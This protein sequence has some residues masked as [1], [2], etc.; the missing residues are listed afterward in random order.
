[1]LNHITHH[2]ARRG[3]DTLSQRGGSKPPSEVDLEAIL[4]RLFTSGWPAAI[5]WSTIIGFIVASVV[6]NYVGELAVALAIVEAS[7][8][9]LSLDKPT[10]PKAAATS[11]KESLLDLEAPQPATVPSGTLVT[12]K[13]CSTLNH[14]R[15]TE[16]VRGFFR[17]FR[18]YAVYQGLGAVVQGFLTFFL[19]QLFPG[20]D[21]VATVLV[22]V[23]MCRLHCAWTHAMLRTTSSDVSSEEDTS[24]AHRG[25]CSI[26]YVS[27]EDSRRLVLPTLRLGFSTIIAKYFLTKSL[28]F[29]ESTLRIRGQTMST[30]GVVAVA[31]FPLLVALIGT[32]Y[33]VIPSW[34]ALVRIEAS[35]LPETDGTIVPLD[36]TF[37]GR[38]VQSSEQS[39]FRY[40]LS[41]ITVRG[42]WKTFPCSTFRRVI[43]AVV[44]FSVLTIVLQCAFV[45][46]FVYEVFTFAGKEL[47][48]YFEYIMQQMQKEMEKEMQQRH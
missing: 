25:R 12:K 17:G 31:L 48:P 2:L 15:R 23:F 28:N 35:L 1:M 26:R 8:E 21:S 47:M 39:R 19:F 42:A 20:G 11:E 7:P 4:R 3:L 24:K 9:S 13:I 27:R 22:S 16:G 10:V 33:F 46:L 6:L 30:A 45:A 36:R 29:T 37:D 5:V 40:I 41:N 32:F 43:K 14:L 34:I 38:L 18:T 44:K